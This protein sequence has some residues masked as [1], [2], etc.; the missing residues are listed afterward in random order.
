ML[1]L[2]PLSG[3]VGLP[4]S[5][6]RGELPGPAHARRPS[7]GRV[8]PCVVRSRRLEGPLIRTLPG[9]NYPDRSGQ[10][11][12]RPRE[13][14]EAPRSL[15]EAGVSVTP[16]PG[17]R[18]THADGRHTCAHTRCIQTQT[19]TP[20]HARV[21]SC[22]RARTHSTCLHLTCPCVDTLTHTC[23]RT[24]LHRI[25]KLLSRVTGE[26]PPRSLPRFDRIL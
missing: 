18:N 23:T 22:I 19:D 10:R 8:T 13:R 9:A 5:Q 14:G 12:L 4:V 11:L 2:P 21:R 6:P 3:R 25:N 26:T 17:E 15:S 20:V 1:L 24:Y 7:R 16:E